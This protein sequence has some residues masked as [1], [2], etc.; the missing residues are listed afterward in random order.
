MRR[1]QPQDKQSGLN[2][3]I[4]RRDFI[5]STLIGAGAALLHAPCPA[6]AQRLGA[7]WTGYGGVGD[8]RSSNGN[9]AEVVQSAHR[10]RDH[11]YEG[12]LS[13]V[14]ETGEEYDVVIVGGGFAGLTAL[15]EF[16]KRKPRGTCLLL[17]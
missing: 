14:I 13:N 8:Y 16:R 9:T 11:A 5:G 7:S 2:R 4:T 15:Y 10:I 1:K 6:E 12:G 3:G 17:D